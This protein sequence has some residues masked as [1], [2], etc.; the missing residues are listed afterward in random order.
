MAGSDLEIRS[1]RSV[2][3]LERRVYQIDTLRLNPGGVPLRGIAYAVALAA[4]AIAAGEIPGLS[5]LVA[6]IPW[7]FRYLA[8]P[9]GAAGLL[10]LVRI[11]GRPFHVAAVSIIRHGCAP[12]QLHSAPRGNRPGRTWRPPP[13][14]CIA[15]GS[16]SVPRALRYRGPGAVLVSYPHDRVEWSARPRLGRRPH[17]SLHPVHGYSGHPATALE[18]APGA[19]LLVSSDPWRHGGAAGL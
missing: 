18:L 17:I 7:Y 15:D 2:F 6:Q 5:W 10:T 14:V 12:E 9:G 3:S 1:F 8:F 11:E 4:V 13:I 16:G 19:V